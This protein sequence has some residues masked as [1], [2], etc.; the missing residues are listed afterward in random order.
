MSRAPTTLG[1]GSSANPSTLGQPVTITASVF[2]ATGSGETGTVTF[3]YDGAVIGSGSVSNGQ[4]TLTTATLPLGT[5]SVTA[6]YGG[7]GNFTG[8]ATT[9]PWSQEVDPAPPEHPAKPN[10]PWAPANP[11]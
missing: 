2:P 3:L 9:A 11:K 4:A 8:S 7:D 10:K 6:T 5:G 1:L